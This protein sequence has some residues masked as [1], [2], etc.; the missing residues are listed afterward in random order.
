MVAL[1]FAGFSTTIAQMEI[2]V[3]SF[4]DSFGVSRKTAIAMVV[5]ISSLLAIPCV[6]NDAFFSFFD[7]LV[8]NVLY[9]ITA[10]GLA[11]YLAWV[12]GAKKIREQWYN[13]TSAIKYGPWVDVLY[14]F[15]A[16]PALVYFA[17]MAVISMF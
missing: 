16:V 8:G 6:W 15:I 12:V 1:F 13:P 11:L 17:I 9:C 4:M 10:G 7:N 2:P 14:K 3:I 5:V